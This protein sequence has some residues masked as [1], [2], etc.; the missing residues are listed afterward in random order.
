MLACSRIWRGWGCFGSN[1][2]DVVARLKKIVQHY[3][4]NSHPM[5]LSDEGLLSV[6]ARLCEIVRDQGYHARARVAAGI[7][8]D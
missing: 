8:D 4:R 2:G 5:D 3:S 7:R 1:G 6:N